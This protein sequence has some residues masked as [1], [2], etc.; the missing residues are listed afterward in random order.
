MPCHFA[1]NAIS[2][3]PMGP[4]RKETGLD[5]KMRRLEETLRAMGSV[6]VALSGGCDSAFLLRAA[7]DALGAGNVAALTAVSP[8][9]PPGEL[10]EARA[11]ARA[12][13]VRHRIVP[14]GEMADGEFTS[15]PPTRC[16]RCKRELFTLCRAAADELGLACVADG[17]NAGDLGDFRPGRD[18]AREAGVRSPLVEAGLGK[19]DVRALS[20]RLG[21]RTWDK[22]AGACLASRIPYGTEITPER[23]RR[24]GRCEEFLRRRG[25]S[26]VRVR[27]HGDTARI[28]GKVAD[29]RALLDE[30]A[31]GAV[32]RFF[33]RQGFVYVTVD[34]EG[35]RTGSMNEALGAPRDR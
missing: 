13:G 23:L 4:K 24:V 25:L 33:K 15:N 26:P 20:R 18:A 14:S 21:L 31:R 10:R 6:L 35:Y 2:I 17:S 30:P 12:A 28:E 3:I 34:L 19:A 27:L 5:A 16:Y 29:L 32:V 11:L 8:T 9:H 7:R 1:R 22:P